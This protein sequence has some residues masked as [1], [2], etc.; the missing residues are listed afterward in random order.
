[1]FLSNKRILLSSP[2]RRNKCL[3]KSQWLLIA[4]IFVTSVWI[5]IFIWLMSGTWQQQL[6]NIPYTASPSENKGGYLMVLI[7]IRSATFCRLFCYWSVR[8][9]HRNTQKTHTCPENVAKSFHFPCAFYSACATTTLL[10]KFLFGSCIQS[11]WE[12]KMC[13]ILMR[14]ET[15]TPNHGDPIQHSSLIWGTLN[16]I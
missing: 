8:K 5:A 3:V 1:M 10:Q 9:Q 7:Y 13:H 12:E 11:S 6:Q 4:W 14:I 2:C 15:T 16:L